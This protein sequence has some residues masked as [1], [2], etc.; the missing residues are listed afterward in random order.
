VTG[1]FEGIDKAANQDWQGIDAR[2]GDTSAADLSI[3]I[4]DA[5]SAA[6]AAT[7]PRTRATGSPTRRRSTG[8]ARRCSRSPAGPATRAR[9]RP[10]SS[11]SSTATS[12]STRSTTRR[13]RRIWNVPLDDLTFYATQDGP[14]WDDEDGSMFKRFNR[15]LPIEAWLIDEVPTSAT[16]AAT[17]SSPRRT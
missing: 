6:A 14:D 9:S 12:G 13:R 7:A 15:A 8:S 3:S 16:T 4:M 5:A 1:T 2:N 11:T 10:A 17:G